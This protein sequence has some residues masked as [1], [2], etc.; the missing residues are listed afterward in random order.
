MPATFDA[1]KPQRW[2]SFVC[3]PSAGYDSS[4]LLPISSLSPP[5]PK[6]GVLVHADNNVCGLAMRNNGIEL[7]NDTV[8]YSKKKSQKATRK[9]T[10]P[11]HCPP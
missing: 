8:L 9:H 1:C 5:P 3:E 7:R 10:H 6:D 2:V 11:L 4:V